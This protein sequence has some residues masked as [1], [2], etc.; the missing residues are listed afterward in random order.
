MIQFETFEERFQYLMLNGIVGKE[1]FG[2]DRTINQQFYRSAEW[3]AVRNRVIVRDL[4]CDLGVQG[5]EI[6]G[7]IYVHHMNP[8]NVEDIYESSEY[9]FNEE[10]L[11][12]M[13]LDTHN[14]IH[15]GD[16]A[17]LQRNQFAER[18]P[19]DMAPWRRK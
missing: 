6:F 10:F 1:T 18:T 4:G 5:N 12:C 14:A 3:K 16:M 15:F 19:D 13:S 9:L 2:F 11:I 7:R 8:I 17:Y